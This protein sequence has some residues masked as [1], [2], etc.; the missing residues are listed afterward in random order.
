MADQRMTPEQEERLVQLL[1][2]RDEAAFRKLLHHYQ[3]RVYNIAFRM[4]GNTH[5]AEDLAQEVFITVFRSIDTFRGEAM[6]STW[7]YRIAVNHA[8]NRLKYFGRRRRERTHSID[9]VGEGAL[10]NPIGTTIPQPDRV[11]MGK[12]LEQVIARAIAALEEEH[13]I[14]IV[15]R[16]FENLSYQEIAAITGLADGTVKSRLHR[17]RLHIK[18]AI[19]AYRAGQPNH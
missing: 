1:K 17:A 19:D 11:L 15:L 14:L 12:E 10:T 2:K 4:L 13:R 8:K 16:E 6:L 7:I 5:E 9:D 18:E 3:H